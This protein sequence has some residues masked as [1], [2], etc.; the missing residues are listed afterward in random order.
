MSV[1]SSLD[2]ENLCLFFFL[3][4][5]S[6]GFRGPALGFID[7]SLVFFYFLSLISTP[8]FLLLTRVSF[9]PFSSFLWELR[10]VTETFL[11]S[12]VGVQCHKPSQAAASHRCWYVVLSFSLN[13]KSFL[14]PFPFFLS[15]RSWFFRKC[16]T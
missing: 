10:P 6:R 4:S 8:H 15:P 14:F 2:V 9:S 1:D 12:P 13:S 16:V 7:F 3:L 5:L 11:L